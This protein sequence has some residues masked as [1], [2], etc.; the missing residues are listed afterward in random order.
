MTVGMWGLRRERGG[1]GQ[2]KRGEG[3]CVRVIG[4]MGQRRV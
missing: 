4:E 2:I 3:N 1:G